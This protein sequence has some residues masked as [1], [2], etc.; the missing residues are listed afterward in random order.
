MKRGKEGWLCPHNVEERPDGEDTG[1]RQPPANQEE[2][3]HQPTEFCW[4]LELG[5]SS[6][7][8]F[9]KINF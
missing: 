5:L 8:N 7:Q 1:R 2:G 9:E 3:P 4:K 6:F